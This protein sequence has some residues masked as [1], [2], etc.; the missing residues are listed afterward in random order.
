MRNVLDLIVVGSG[1]GGSLLAMIARRLGLSVVMIEKSSHPRFVIGESTTPL[2]NLYLEQIADRYQLPQLRSLSK[3]GTW[4]ASH[5]E[6]PVGLKRG[7]SFFHHELGEP[8]VDDPGHRHQLL[9]AASPHD[10]I[11]DTHWYRPAFDEQLVKWAVEAGVEYYDR[12]LVTDVRFQHEAVTATFA[13]EGAS[14]MVEA[15][16]LV[17]A[18]GPDGFLFNEL[19]LTGGSFPELPDR[20]TLFTHFR[21]VKPFPGGTD[22]SDQEPPYP[23]DD[24]AVHHLFDGG[25]IWV[26]KFN[27]G[28]T[29]A[30]VSL[31][32]DNALD[33]TL[34]EGAAAWKRLLEE[35]PAV[36]D[37]FADAEPVM[38]FTY[39]PH[40]SFRSERTTG[41]RWAMLPAAAGFVDPMMSIGFPLNLRGIMRL[42]AIL[43]EHPEDV[44]DPREGSLS[45]YEEATRKEQ[46]L[47]SLMIGAL[48]A[49][50]SDFEL[51]SSLALIYFAAASYSESAIRLGKPELASS[52]LLDD[53]PEFGPRARRCYERA[54]SEPTPAERDELMREIQRTIAPFDVAGLTDRSRRNWYPVRAQD[55]LG[56]A[57]R[58]HSTE[59]EI[60]ESLTRSGFWG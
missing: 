9:V 25:W 15:R 17:D 57:D 10:G 23:A 45:S 56:H 53:H 24:A 58:L 42:A 32:K 36:G 5:H 52:F 13:R 51:F 6:I 48:W 29:S 30:G 44:R 4:Q 18:T 43:E 22:P 55:I 31:R 40:M 11:G 59:E 49:N 26:L 54:L 41:T 47:G 12:A 1:F 38:P 14:H 27:N 20:E 3:W 28:I 60:R 16:L 37:Q 34:K 46:D 50:F 35:L 2:T 33:L 21:G 19:K 8:F 39:R 7:F